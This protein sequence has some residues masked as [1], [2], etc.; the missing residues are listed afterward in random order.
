MLIL[1]AG[2]Q[3]H[4]GLH[5]LHAARM[6]AGGGRFGGRTSSRRGQAQPLHTTRPA[7]AV[8]AAAL[9][10]GQRETLRSVAI[11]GAAAVSAAALH[12][13][14]LIRRPPQRLNRRRP[15]RRPHFI[16]AWNSHP[17]RVL[18]AGC[19]GRFGGRTSSRRC[20]HAR[21]CAQSSGGGRFGGRTSS[22]QLL[23]SKGPPRM[24]GGGCFGGRTSSRLSE[25][26]AAAASSLAAA[27]SAAAL[28]RGSHK[29]GPR[30]A[31]D[32]RL[33]HPGFLTHHCGSPASTADVAPSP[34]SRANRP[35]LHCGVF[36][37]LG[38]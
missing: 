16:E 14:R 11:E 10:R 33:N 20:C 35:G 4:R 29:L 36:N 17:F 25:S 2:Q 37:E 8:S 21:W 24:A 13:G 26:I 38:S 7:A 6:L 27:V 12:R 9:H 23:P 30:K 34:V 3:L 15:F 1:N 28:H 31:R 18:N 19:G 32:M 5:A 22:R